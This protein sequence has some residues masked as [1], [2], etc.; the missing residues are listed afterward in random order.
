MGTTHVG[1][2]PSF[3]HRLRGNLLPSAKPTLRGNKAALGREPAFAL[4]KGSSILQRDSGRSL[5][6]PRG[7][8][9]RAVILGEPG[10]EAFPGAVN[11]KILGQVSSPFTRALRPM[12]I[13]LT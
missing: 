3:P 13:L 8:G 12:R 7:E 1:G 10:D 5:P 6:L 4:A 2:M 11:P 9:H